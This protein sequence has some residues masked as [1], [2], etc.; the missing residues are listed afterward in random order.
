MEEDENLLNWLIDFKQNYGDDVTSY[1]DNNCYNAVNQ[2]YG[3]CDNSYSCPT[4]NTYSLNDIFGSSDDSNGNTFC[5]NGYE[6]GGWYNQHA[7]GSAYF[8]S[9]DVLCG[10]SEVCELL[11]C[12]WINSSFLGCFVINFDFC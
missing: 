12:F 7:N 4:N 6:S 11:A 10:G 5:F 3:Y 1:L 8:P 2:D 9:S